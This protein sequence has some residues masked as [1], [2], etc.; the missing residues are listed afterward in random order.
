MKTIPVETT[1]I[2]TQTGEASIETTRAHLM[3]PHPDACQTCGMLPAHPPDQPHN[4]QS[5]YYQYAFYGEHGRWPT[6]KDAIAH[7]SD[8]V[9]AAWEEALRERGVW[10][11]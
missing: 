1:T 3:P 11:E 6:W 9:R 10:P 2:D 5:L 4:A 7:C 8:E